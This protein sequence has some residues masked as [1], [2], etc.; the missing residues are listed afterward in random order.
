MLLK[1]MVKDF[2]LNRSLYSLVKGSLM[3]SFA[4]GVS[5]GGFQI[6]LLIIASYIDSKVYLI[7]MLLLGLE[8]LL[9]MLYLS[10][11]PNLLYKIIDLFPSHDVFSVTTLVSFF[12]FI[13]YCGFLL[14]ARGSLSGYY[15]YAS[16]TVYLSLALNA[17]LANQFVYYS[18]LLQLKGIH[19]QA[20]KFRSIPFLFSFVTA[21]IGFYFFSDKV[22]GFFLG[23]TIGFLIFSWIFF[24][25][26]LL[27]TWVSISVF[28][29]VFSAIVS[30]VPY[31]FSIAL[32]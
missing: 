20:V 22:A 29:D 18:V 19:K 7:L 5:K 10:H 1:G 17:Y 16:T 27:R 30:R 6:L 23:K 32:M 8:S 21:L 14:L 4:E 11:Y 28:K 9:K 13:I 3:Y 24:S 15:E 12:Q 31:S 2:F 26:S 25:R